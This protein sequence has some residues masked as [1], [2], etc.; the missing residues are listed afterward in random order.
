V[1]ANKSRNA[2][3]TDLQ[4]EGFRQVNRA[5]FAW[6]GGSSR[7]EAR[8]GNSGRDGRYDPGG[9]DELTDPDT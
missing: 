2:L 7:I 5:I 4:V 6:I 3:F 8:A 1:T 9:E